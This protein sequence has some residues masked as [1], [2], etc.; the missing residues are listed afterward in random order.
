[1]SVP[2]E[3]VKAWAPRSS[4]MELGWSVRTP[5]TQALGRAAGVEPVLPGDKAAGRGAV[6]RVHQGGVIL[7]D[8]AGIKDTHR[9][10]SPGFLKDDKALG[11]PCS[12]G[13]GQ[14]TQ[15]NLC[16]DTPAGPS[17]RSHHREQC[18]STADMSARTLG[19]G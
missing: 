9:H 10:W 8:T 11:L 5:T 14:S 19:P 17:W 1:M 6:P 18:D 3:E 13:R 2:W 15:P 12:D 4:Q 7:K 16:P